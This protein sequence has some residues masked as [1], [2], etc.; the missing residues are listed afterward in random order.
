MST[1]RIL[2]ESFSSLSFSSDEG[3]FSFFISSEHGRTV[4]FLLWLS[5]DEMGWTASN[6]FCKQWNERLLSMQEDSHFTRI[7]SGHYVFCPM[8]WI[9]SMVF[10]GF[11]R[12]R[13]IRYIVIY[14]SCHYVLVPTNL[15]IVLVVQWMPMA[16]VGLGGSNIFQ[17]SCRLF[18]FALPLVPATLTPACLTEQNCSMMSSLAP[19]EN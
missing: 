10:W 5:H 17:P 14:M 7:L 11:A 13:I 16:G 3:K 1:S 8:V 19:C 4:A 2:S 12:E 9:P 15:Y 18:F 6:G